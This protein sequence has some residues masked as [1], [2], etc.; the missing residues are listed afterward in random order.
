MWNGIVCVC[1]DSV[2]FDSIWNGGR[3]Q[4]ENNPVKKSRETKFPYIKSCWISMFS[5][6]FSIFFKCWENFD[7]RNCLQCTRLIKINNVYL[8]TILALS[9]DRSIQIGVN[10]PF[11]DIWRYSIWF[12]MMLMLISSMFCRFRMFDSNDIWSRKSL[13]RKKKDTPSQCLSLRC[14]KI[15]ISFF[16]TNPSKFYS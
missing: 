2:R 15:S 16:R 12:S 11:A 1:F 7:E 4:K 14:C 6:I 13:W 9:I 8:G 3:I 5:E 10:S